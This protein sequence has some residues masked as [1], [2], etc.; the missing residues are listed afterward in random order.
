MRGSL[1]VLKESWERNEKE[2]FKVCEWI[3]QLQQ[4]LQVIR[5]SAMK[6]RSLSKGSHEKNYNRKA[7]PREFS[8]VLLRVPGM[9][10]KLNDAWDR[11]YEVHKQVRDGGDTQCK[12]EK[13][14]GPC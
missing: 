10:G 4:R 3:E 2:Q 6:K 13:E 14:I 1:E 11:P 8:M 9:C 12:G 7:K 5:N